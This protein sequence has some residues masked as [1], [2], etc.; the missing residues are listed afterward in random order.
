MSSNKIIIRRN[1]ENA[2]IHNREM[3]LSLYEYELKELI[4]EFKESLKKDNDDYIFAVT[5]HDND[6]AMVLIDKQGKIYIN[7]DARNKLKTLWKEPYLSNMQR[8]IP[9]FAKQLV[10]NEISVNGVKVKKTGNK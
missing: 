2:L 8:L 4:S 9:Q 3:V 10:K 7:E 5:E 6:V 1:L